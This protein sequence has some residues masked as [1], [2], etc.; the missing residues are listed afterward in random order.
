MIPSLTQCNSYIIIYQFQLSKFKKGEI[1]M[2]PSLTQ[3]NSYIII[4]QFQLS[5]F[6]KREIFIIPSL[7]QCNSYIIIDQFQLSK[8]KKGNFIQY[9]IQFHFIQSALLFWRKPW[10][11]MWSISLNAW[12]KSCSAPTKFGPLSEHICLT[13]PLLGITLL[14]ARMKESVVILCE[15]SMCTALLAI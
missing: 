15:T 1:F 8:F 13:F 14:R 7:T 4:C 5:K 11:F 2:I 3:S 10:I 12:I 6:K 9:H